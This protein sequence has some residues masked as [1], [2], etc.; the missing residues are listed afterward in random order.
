MKGALSV[1]ASAYKALF[2]GQSTPAQVLDFS[3]SVHDTSEH[4]Q[5]TY[6]D[7]SVYYTTV[8]GR[9]LSYN[10]KL[11]NMEHLKGHGNRKK[12]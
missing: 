2:T 10:L 7:F 5:S 6:I 12:I 11:T 4:K 9:N 1:A 8:W 3:S